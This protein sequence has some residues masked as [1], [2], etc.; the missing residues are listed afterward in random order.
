MDDEYDALLRDE[1][2]AASHAS[3]PMSAREGWRD[4][5]R[6]D[7]WRAPTRERVVLVDDERP[8][9]TTAADAYRGGA[10]DSDDDVSTTLS[11]RVMRVRHT[12]RERR[13]PSSSRPAA[14]SASSHRGEGSWFDAPRRDRRDSDEAFD[15]GAAHH[16]LRRHP[17]YRSSSSEHGGVVASPAY[18]MPDD[19]A[20]RRRALD[21]EEER[22]RHH[23]A[24]ATSESD[25]DDDKPERERSPS[26]ASAPRSSSSPDRAPAA[27]AVPAL[28]SWPWAVGAE[29][30]AES[31]RAARAVLQD[32]AKAGDDDASVRR[33][34]LAR[35]AEWLR[36]A[37]PAPT[38]AYESSTPDAAAAPHG[39][40]VH[41]ATTRRTNALH[42]QLSLQWRAAVGNAVQDCQRRLDVLLTARRRIVRETHAELDALQRV[43]AAQVTRVE[44]QLPATQHAGAVDLI[45]RRLIA[46][47]ARLQA[48]AERDVASALDAS[49][50]FACDER[51]ATATRAALDEEAQ[52]ASALRDELHDASAPA[53][54]ATVLAL[55]QR[56]QAAVRDELGRWAAHLSHAASRAALALH[57]SS[58][59]PPP[60]GPTSGL[61]VGHRRAMASL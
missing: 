25:H 37:T 52:L 14:S 18:D 12:E 44:Q 53:A 19:A 17:A 28:A 16:R 45:R 39:D 5:R 43:A 27:V 33:A 3:A 59:Q 32:D 9:P 41:N 48:D 7:D 2:R 55:E 61:D 49:M 11:Q 10:V 40:A 57:A 21:G 42:D 30:C 1:V 4:D 56:Q 8:R 47:A 24:D 38:R 51:V 22:D 34:V 35:L 6:D 36:D 23:R 29:L 20:D 26:H 13:A 60:R 31:A 58:S 50:P 54:R 46:F 15:G